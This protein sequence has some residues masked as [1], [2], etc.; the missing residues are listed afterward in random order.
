MSPRTDAGARVIT[1]V[2]IRRAVLKDLEAD[3]DLDE[4]L[5]EVRTARGLGDF[6]R[7]RRGLIELSSA[8]MNVAE[9]IPAPRSTDA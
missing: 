9:R 1:D 5:A 7:L 3:P 4:L 2:I 8:S 6:A